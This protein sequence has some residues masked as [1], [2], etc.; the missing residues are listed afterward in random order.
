MY[1]Y[2]SKCR[3]N[4]LL[5]IDSEIIEIRPG[6]SFSSKNLLVSR[7]LE[8]IEPPAI[9]KIKVKKGRPKKIETFSLEDNI[10]GSSST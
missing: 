2:M 3:W 10:N 9:K 4:M 8:V 5:C 1:Q 7:Y 6:E